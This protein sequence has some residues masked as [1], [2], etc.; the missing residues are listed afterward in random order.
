MI[1]HNFEKIVQTGLSHLQTNSLA[2]AEKSFREALRLNKRHPHLLH[3]L[4]VTCWRQGNRLEGLKFFRSAIKYDSK[5][6]MFHRDLGLALVESGKTGEA[7]SVLKKALSLSPNEVETRRKLATSLAQLG[8][9][10]EAVAEFKTI[11]QDEPGSAANH[12]NLGEMHS[13]LGQ[14]ESAIS[15]FKK[16]IALDPNYAFAWLNLGNVELYLGRKE[17][18]IESFDRAIELKPDLALAY[19]NRGTAL[20][21]YQ[22]D[23]PKIKSMEDLQASF[24][25]NDHDRKLY[26]FALSKVYEDLSDYDKSFHFLETGNRIRKEELKY[27][28]D[29]DIQLINSIKECF[30]NDR[31]LTDNSFGA[32]RD[33]MPIFIVGMLRSGTSLVEQI[34]AAHSTV[35]GAGEVEAM[36][37]IASDLLPKIF[38]K[39]GKASKPIF[40]KEDIT[41]VHNDYLAALHNFEFTEQIVT[42]K[43]PYNFLWIGLILAAFPEA[44]IVHLNRDPRATCWSIYKHYFANKQVGYAYDLDELATYYRLYQELMSF[45]R[46]KFPGRIHELNYEALTVEPKAESKKLLSYCGLDWED[47]C[48]D[49]HKDKRAVRTLSALQVR[50]EI[51][52]GSSDEWRKFEAHLTPLLQGLSYD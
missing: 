51:Y 32:P 21:Q 38:V 36:T 22:S 29:D 11:T 37:N 18:A 27:S 35:F 20:G 13:R 24:A 10:D 26:S 50:R 28:L 33:L 39:K 47:R 6:G 41:R 15:C 7:I 46:K 23:D 48:L 2:S 14:I 30:D 8:R 5:I 31:P 43:M 44:K 9:I 49:F 1:A 3:L 16:A 17:E 25:T 34:L 19:V 40:N 42:D 4:G 52:Q 12:A 45:W